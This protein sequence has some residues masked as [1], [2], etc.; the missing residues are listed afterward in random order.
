MNQNQ[1]FEQTRWKL[2]TWYAAILGMILGVCGLGLYE[3]VAHAHRITINQ[4]LK[5]VAGTLH[6]SLEPLLQQPGKL[7]V[8]A[9]GLLPELCVVN[10]N[11]FKVSPQQR[12]LVG[13]IQQG[14]YYIHLFSLSGKLIAVAG[15][16]P[17]G[18]PIVY[19]E[20]EWDTLTDKEGIRYR[21]TS[22]TLHTQDYQDWGY[23]QVGR[24]LQDFDNYVAK[25]KWLLLLGLPIAI[26][27]VLVVSWWLAGRA[28][29]P[30]YQSYR[31]LQQ[32]TADAAHELRTPLGAIRATVEST[33]LLPT[34]TEQEARDT[35]AKIERQN[36]RLS[37][38]VADLLMLSRMEQ[39]L[40]VLPDA[41]SQWDKVSLQDVVNDVAEELASLALAAQ[42]TLE[43][44]I[45]VS[46]PLL[47]LGNEEQLYRLVFNLVVNGIEHTKPG[48][49]VKLTLATDKQEALIEITD[50]GTG[51]P[52][53]ELGRIFD[54]FYR[55]ER[56]RSR[57]RGG[58]GLGLAIAKAIAQA[59]QGSISVKS[60][61][62][63]GSMFTIRLPKIR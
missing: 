32:F 11:C 12:H 18:L 35:L 38:L 13:A 6:D 3:A 28:M 9:K 44:Q 21:Q 2:A 56:S 60:Q 42:I 40:T 43:T 62:G 1:L 19:R 23:L 8:T 5:T 31:Q 7:E 30:I 58:S 61:L 49:Q 34:V 41:K 26:L 46:Q 22:L 63:K 36:Q 53:V 25:V 10:D 16:Q 37:Y 33:L 29:Q 14:K 17:P 39:Q 59:H 51:I 20:Q 24:S 45:L 55:V 52:E 15:M 48:G 4:E 57:H 47:V 50:T 27:L 54:R